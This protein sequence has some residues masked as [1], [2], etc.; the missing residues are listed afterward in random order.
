MWLTRFGVRA[1]DYVYPESVA[2]KKSPPAP[3]TVVD[4]IP[5]S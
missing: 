1:T 3:L 2:G 4:L 5:F